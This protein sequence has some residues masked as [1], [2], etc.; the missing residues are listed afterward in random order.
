M[1]QLL[2]THRKMWI[3]IFKGFLICFPTL[4]L[5]VCVLASSFIK[6]VQAFWGELF[7]ILLKV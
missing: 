4:C 2:S 3:L 1:K 5:C 7:H 6:P